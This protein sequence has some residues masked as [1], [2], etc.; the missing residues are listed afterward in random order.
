MHGNIWCS[1]RRV[2]LACRCP[3]AAGLRS[4]TLC[5]QLGPANDVAIDLPTSVVLVVWQQTLCDEARPKEWCEHPSDLPTKG[6]AEGTHAREGYPVAL[7]R[8]SAASDAVN[9]V[10]EAWVGSNSF[11]WGGLRDGLA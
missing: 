11:G 6:C 2:H 3:A 5:L 4:P 9:K 7:G 1:V 10:F 8:E